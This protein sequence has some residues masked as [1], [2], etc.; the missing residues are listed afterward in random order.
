MRKVSAL[1]IAICGLLLFASNASAQS[2][3]HS[4]V[5]IVNGGVSLHIEKGTY[6]S[7]FG[8][9][10]HNGRYGNG[11]H[12]NRNRGW[13]PDRHRGWHNRGWDNG[14]WR[15]GGDNIVIIQ[16]APRIEHYQPIQ[17]TVVETR[18]VLEPVYVRDRHGRLCET[19]QFRKVWKEVQV[20]YTAHWSPQYGSYVY[21][22]SQGVLRYY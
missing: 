4:S 21:T 11:V 7:S 2:Y 16:P 12:I 18:E 5:S 22:D 10:V 1:F 13:Y 17:F 15:R 19:G 3:S 20:L 8:L 9:S 6:G 14:Q